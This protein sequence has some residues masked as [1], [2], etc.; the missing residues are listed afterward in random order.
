[1]KSPLLYGKREPHVKVKQ[2]LIGAWVSLHGTYSY[3]VVVRSSTVVTLK[4]STRRGCGLRKLVYESV[5]ALYL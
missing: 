5:A 3:P 2:S 1:M 4:P